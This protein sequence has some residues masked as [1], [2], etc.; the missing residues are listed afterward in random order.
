M[1][2]TSHFSD[3]EGAGFEV[4]SPQ[5]RERTRESARARKPR[6]APECFPARW[7]GNPLRL[8]LTAVTTCYI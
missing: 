3:G 5:S 6:P 1:L 4:T 7:L 8:H 2:P